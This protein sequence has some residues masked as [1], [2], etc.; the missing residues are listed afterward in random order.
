[1]KRKT[2]LLINEKAESGTTLYLT[3]PDIKKV[4]AIKSAMTAHEYVGTYR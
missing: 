1:M 4:R 3:F 2:T